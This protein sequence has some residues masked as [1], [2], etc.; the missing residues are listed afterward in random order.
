VRI[1]SIL[2]FPHIITSGTRSITSDG[3]S[4]WIDVELFGV[5]HEVLGGGDAVVEC[6]RKYVFG[7]QTITVENIFPHCLRELFI[8][9]GETI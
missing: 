1:L 2:N 9:S 7:S 8:E 5:R 6:G 3:D 4:R